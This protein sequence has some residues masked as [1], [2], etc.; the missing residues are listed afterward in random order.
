ML[1]QLPNK[2]SGLDKFDMQKIV[3]SIFLMIASA[4]AT[5]SQAAVITFDT[6]DSF[7]ANGRIKSIGD[8]EFSTNVQSDYT[9]GFDRFLLGGTNAVSYNAFGES[10]EFFTFSSAVTLNSIDFGIHSEYSP[11]KL[12]VETFDG[13]DNLLSSMEIVLSS[14]LTT[15]N[16]GVSNVSKVLLTFTGGHDVLTSD[17]LHAWYNLDNI[18]YSTAIVPVPA[19][20]PLLLA[21]FGL[22]GLVGR[23]KLRSS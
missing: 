23:Y 3:L 19:S 12:I 17:R 18:N 13:S 2:I 15:Y 8:V 20:L 7:H 9:D 14:V 21:G 16:F 4:F 10:G 6:L 22:L 5:G 1:E 11:D